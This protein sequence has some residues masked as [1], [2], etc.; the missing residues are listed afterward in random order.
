MSQPSWTPFG[1][2]DD[3]AREYAVLVP[4]VSPQMRDSLLG[5]LGFVLF[6]GGWAR[7]TYCLQLQTTL[8]VNLRIDPSGLTAQGTVENSLRRL[9]DLEIL[10]VVDY[11]LSTITA[12]DGRSRRSALER[13]LLAGRSRWTVGERMGHPGLV[14]RVAEGVQVSVE[15]VIGN[16]GNAGNILARAW[17]QVHGLTPNDSGAYADCVRAAEIAAIAK[18]QPNH[19]TATLGTVLGQMRADGDWRLPLRE[20]PDAPGP[21]TV[22]TLIRTL[23]HGHRDRHGSVDYSDVTHDEARA[24]VMLAAAVIDWFESGALERRPPAAG[25]A[26]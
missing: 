14:E 25:D 17:A 13:I 11:T 2:S 10:R 1:M 24:A 23:W 15:S 3:E 8:D 4:H 19:S 21:E 16:S 6:D 20:H 22:L 9:S 7:T 26:A 18:V 5:W 12:Y